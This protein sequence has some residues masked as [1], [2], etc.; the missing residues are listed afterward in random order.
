MNDERD[1]QVGVAIDQ[2]QVPPPEEDFFIRLRERIAGE[3]S[4]SDEEVVV[5]P[6]RRLRRWAWVAAAAALVVFGVTILP[7]VGPF[8]TDSALAAEVKAKVDHARV[9]IHTLRGT[10]FVKQRLP[11]SEKFEESLST[12]VSSDDGSFRTRSTTGSLDSSYYAPRRLRRTYFRYDGDP[13]VV[14]E[15]SEFAIELTNAEHSPSDPLGFVEIESG[16]V[17]RAL[18]EARDPKVKKVSYE[19]RQAWKVEFKL[20]ASPFA[21]NQSIDRTVVIID[22]ET[23]L[24]VKMQSFSDDG[25]EREVL[26][27]DVIVDSPVTEQDFMAVFPRGAKVQQ[28]D[29]GFRAS[30]ESDAPRVLSYEPLLPRQLPDGYRLASLT[31]NPLLEGATNE[32]GNKGPGYKNLLVATYRRGLDVIR[33]FNYSEEVADSEH[34]EDEGPRPTPPNYFEIAKGGLA[35]ARA[36]IRFELGISPSAWVRHRGIT[37]VVSGDLTPDGIRRLLEGFGPEA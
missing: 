17:A 22:Q 33:V 24:P 18:V 14:P 5:L 36:E 20:P 16:S 31:V 3:V 13:G 29:G 27:R 8:G 6:S 11:G 10:I 1:R 15:F 7:K 12:F 34:S 28:H 2:I 25:L 19:G 30:N 9:S 23:G 35:G 26:L 21:P 4:P 32:V 37:V